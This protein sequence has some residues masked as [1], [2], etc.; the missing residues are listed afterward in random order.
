VKV[1]FLDFDG[2]VNDNSLDGVFVKELFVKELKKVI[3]ITGAKVVV[4]SNKRDNALVSGSFPLEKSLCFKN[5]IQPLEKMGIEIYGYTPFVSGVRV[6][7]AREFEIELF[8][9]KHSEVKEFLIVEDD[10]VMQRLYDHQIFIEYSGG[11]ISEYVEPAVQILNGNLG[12][13][14]PS[15]D[16]RET[17]QERIQRLFPSLFLSS[18]E[19]EEF[20]KKEKVMED[21]RLLLKLE[22]DIGSEK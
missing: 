9:E 2:V 4:S 18:S 16:R 17:F 12:F 8:L 3:D 13:Y 11:F 22:K 10:Y 21:F 6:E 15:Y 5:Y 20:E 1:I 14:P 19:S 7:E